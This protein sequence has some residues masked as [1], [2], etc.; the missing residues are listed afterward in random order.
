MT[1]SSGK[2][3]AYYSGSGFMIRHSATEYEVREPGGKRWDPKEIYPRLVA[4]R[5]YST[6][7][8]LNDKALYFGGF[9]CNHFSSYNSAWVM[10]GEAT[11]VYSKPVPCQKELGCGH[12]P[13]TRFR[14][15][16]CDLCEGQVFDGNEVYFFNKK[17]VRCQNA[18]NWLNTQ[19][20]GKCSAIK[21]LVATATRSC[22]KGICN[23]CAGTG[24]PFRPK[25]PAAKDSAG[26]VLY[27]CRV[28]LG[29]VKS[30]GI[31][32]FRAT[33]WWGGA[34]CW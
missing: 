13:G 28:A 23:L 11:A 25:A 16:G 19:K 21:K 6:S 32:C 26:N 29:F 22:C 18:I 5:T 24:K 1:S 8:F 20:A 15:T 3:L 9:D 14:P 12:V 27:K 31:D 2:R 10:R 7:P 17:R 30:G 4:V 34:C 33:A